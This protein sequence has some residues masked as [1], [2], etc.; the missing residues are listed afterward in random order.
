MNIHHDELREMVAC[1]TSD[2]LIEA[3]E[4]VDPDWAGHFAGDLDRAAGCYTEF[5]EEFAD[6][7]RRITEEIEND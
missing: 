6:E 1:L 2:Q 3:V 7:V 5:C 4:A